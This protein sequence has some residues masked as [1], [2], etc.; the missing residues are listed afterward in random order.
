MK[1]QL[2]NE[3]DFLLALA[4]Q[5][6][7]NLSDA[8]DL[9]QE[10][11]LAALGYVEKG[12][13]IEQVRAFL[14]GVLHHKYYDMLRAKYR[15]PVVTVGETERIAV[16]EKGI[17]SSEGNIEPL[18]QVIREQEAEWI[19]REVAYLAKTYRSVIVAHYFHNKSVKQISEELQL[20][21]GTVKS[22]LDFG[23]KQVK[24]GLETME[25]YK[26]N[27]YMPQQIM[28]RCSGRFGMK[29]EP[30]SLV[31]DD[32]L[33]QNILILAYQKPVTI[34]ELSKAIG[35]ATAYVEPIVR[36]LV[37][38]QLMKQMGDN[39]VYTDFILYDAEDYVKYIHEAEAFV[40]QYGEAY[41]KPVKIAI[42]E[43]KQTDFYSERLE[44]FMLIQIA[45]SGCVESMEAI[46]EKPQ[47]FPERP[48]GGAW[49]AFGTIY[50]EHY[51]IP[52]EKQG[53]EEYAFSGRRCTRVDQYLN[54]G[55]EG[56]K[57]L[58]LLDA[59]IPNVCVTDTELCMYNYE[60]SLHEHSWKKYSGYEFSSFQELEMNM[61]K[62]FYLLEKKIDPIAVDL[63]VRILKGISQMEEA[64]FLTVQNGVPQVLV[65]VLT[66]KQAQQFFS[67]C[68]K[69]QNAFS[70]E[71]KPH[72]AQYCKT[73]KKEIPAHLKS[74]PDQKRTMPYEPNA[75]M[76]V[77]EAIKKGVHPRNLGY[78][79]PE[80]I[81]VFD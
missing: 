42:K 50:P 10:T 76:F 26:E 59:Q 7:G 46:R 44:R 41:I 31:E 11:M 49:I 27:S 61:L 72:F 6:C 15:L 2:Q 67:I 80:T 5:K 43:L 81:V 78:V 73:H 39:R 34:V 66:K 16:W 79:C 37:D 20:P 38:G 64:G 70:E 35:V 19:R 62:F 54:T 9:T 13:V 57:N 45:E 40:E 12:G 18:E 77:Y 68:K 60:T 23:R 69:A 3:L 58:T 17:Q 53:K 8:Q 52:K 4:L 29:E 75:M 48:N 1:Q 71:M 36:K 33:A 56:N 32:V 74:V 24:K 55:C 47:I 30:M 22:R 25:N 28:L 21:V 63:D 51:T 65:P 14:A